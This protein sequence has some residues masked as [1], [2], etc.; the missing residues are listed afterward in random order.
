MTELRPGQHT[1][2]FRFFLT[3][4]KKELPLIALR[5][6]FYSLGTLCT[7]GMSYFLGR[8]VDNL[9]P[10]PT[11]LT[12]SVTLLVAALVFHEIF[13]RIG[14]VLEVITHA[15]I[16]QKIKKALFLYTSKLSFGYFADRFAGQISH[17]IGTAA[18]AM[19][20][21]E[22]MVVNKFIDNAWMIILSAVAMGSIYPPLGIVL[23]VWLFFFLLGVGPFAKRIT[24]YAERFATDESGTTGALVDMYTNI[25]TVKVYS[26]DFGQERLEKQVDTEYESQVVLGKW[27]VFTYGYQ[28][29]SAV[30]LGIAIIVA[31]AYGYT[32]E[33]IS[34]G[35][36][37]AVSGIA[38]K[39]IEY[40]YDTGHTVSDFVRSRGE[41]SQ[42]LRDII[43]TPGIL[44]GQQAANWKS[45]NVVYDRVSF[46]YNEHKQILKDFSLTVSEGQ[47]LGIVGLSGA[48]KTTLVNLL[49]RFFDPTHGS[50]SMNG[51]NIG[52]M[53]QE[54]LRSHISFISQDTSLFHASVLDNIRY[55][56]PE[57]SRE[58]VEE[59]ARMAYAEEFVLQLP[60][61][62]DTIV[63]ERGVKLSG[64]QRQRIAI[65]RAMLKNAPLFLLDEATSAL[66]SD[67]EAKVQKALKTLMLGKT[68]IAI[69]HRLS[70]LQ[71]MD[72]IIF[73]ENGQVLEDG[74]HDELLA[75]NGNYAKLWSMQAGG[76][77]PDEL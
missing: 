36:I 10:G 67:S 31:V 73:I 51:I 77:I 30:V 11:A 70:T 22:E 39:I 4:N 12:Y 47:K 52:A 28:G 69:A 50:I 18:S 46:S 54:S 38:L 23:I 76:F 9:A 68:V 61:G 34:T 33:L 16:R 65:A 40:V 60:Q 53:T 64:G 58:Q 37:V 26:K 43:V 14:H 56:T 59:I 48:G 27:S 6:L 20:R 24:K 1:R 75:L 19:E 17:Q 3:I 62:Y 5:I 29:M 66:D 44:D 71:H 13:Y 41:C 21:M 74:T 32:H 63:G 42:A 72:R 15:R 49:L 55:G 7:V 25:G 8:V 45:V 35:G 57:A 2:L